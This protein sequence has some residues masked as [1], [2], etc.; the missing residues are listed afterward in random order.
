M[1][2][3]II[4]FDSFENS[5][6]GLLR[7]L[8]MFPIYILLTLIWFYFTKDT[9]Y[10]KYIDEVTKAQ[11]IIPLLLS[12]ILVV[13]TLSIHVP[14]NATHAVVYGAL[15][16]FVIYGITNLTLLIVSKKWNYTVS[17]IDTLSGILIFSFLGYVLYKIVEKWPTIF[18]YV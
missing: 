7:G 17:V 1:K 16:G 18:Q 6:I 11:F 10:S 13:S 9:I 14:N 15:A 2:S 4:F 5:K 12:S 8:V 3:T